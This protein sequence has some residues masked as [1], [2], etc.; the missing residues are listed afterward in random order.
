MDAAAVS[1]SSGSAPRAV[2]WRLEAWID[3]A[4]EYRQLADDPKKAIGL[5]STLVL[6]SLP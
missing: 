3:V 5:T 4:P 6:A 1:A 2:A